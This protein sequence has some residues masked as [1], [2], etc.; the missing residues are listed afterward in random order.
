VIQKIWVDGPDVLTWLQLH[1][2]VAPETPVANWC[3]AE[4]GKITR[5]RV[6][7][8]PRGLSAG[9]PSG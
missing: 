1:T 6:A 7:L 3:R 8:D 9:Q 4:D 2:T 5:V